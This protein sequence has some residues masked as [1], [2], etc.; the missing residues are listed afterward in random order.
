M[1]G[2]RRGARDHEVLDLPGALEDRQQRRVTE[3][4]LD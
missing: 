3:P 4:A 2:P 1:D